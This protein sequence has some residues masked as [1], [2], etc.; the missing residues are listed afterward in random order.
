MP[1][2]KVFLSLL[3]YFGIVTLPSRRMAWENDSMFSIPWVASKM[4]VKRFEA[5]PNSWHW[6][7]AYSLGEVE[8]RAC[9]RNNAFWTV[10][11]YCDALCKNFDEHY[12]CPQSFDIDEQRIPSEPG[13]VL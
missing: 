10:Q 5:I 12:T 1:E 3:L 13:K 11:G 7:D 8:R 4:P 9:N 2:V 6:T